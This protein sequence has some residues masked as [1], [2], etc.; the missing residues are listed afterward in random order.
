MV[1]AVGVDEDVVYS[2]STAIQVT[3]GASL[4]H[5]FSFIIVIVPFMYC[6]FFFHNSFQ[7][8]LLGYE[9]TDTIMVLCDEAIYFLASKKKV[10]FLRNV[11]NDK[12][13]DSGI[14]PIK[15][16]VRDKVCA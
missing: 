11:E 12:E 8:W 7:T 9:L 16:L 6:F 14:P 2:K 15:L 13:N 1:V 5:V 10:E 4:L 3:L